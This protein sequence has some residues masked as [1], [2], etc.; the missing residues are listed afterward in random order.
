MLPLTLGQSSRGGR[1][2]GSPNETA[3]W[4]IFI[5]GVGTNAG[6]YFL[7]RYQSD[8]ATFGMIAFHLDTDPATT[9]STDDHALIQLT[10]TDIRA[11]RAN[12][13]RFGETATAIVRKLDRMLSAGD[14]LNGSRTTRALT[15]LAFIYHAERLCRALRKSHTRLRERHKTRRVTPVLISSSGGGTGSPAQILLMELLRDPAFRH[16]LLGAI[17]SDLLLPPMA[18]VV[19]P[20]AFASD[21]SQMQAR[22]IIANSFAFRLESEYML[23]RKAV[24][25]VTHIGHANDAGTV[26]ADPDLM[27]KVLGFAVYEIERCWPALK[28]RWVDGPDDV[29]SITNYG[30]QDS[31]FFDFSN[32]LHV[33][34]R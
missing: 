1:H 27:A 24:S 16:R 22:K 2:S 28:A 7:D 5:G 32:G 30:G 25:Y 34:R 26:L 14:I 13:D 9:L 29:A 12:P 3:F 23:Q 19:E 21:T 33:R 10:S 20:F 8:N 4:N 11:I 18:F 31:P 6:R 17:P 15:Q